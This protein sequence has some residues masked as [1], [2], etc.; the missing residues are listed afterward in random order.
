MLIGVT[1]SIRN[2]CYLLGFGTW[3][4]T[5]LPLARPGA[6]LRDQPYN[7]V[8]SVITLSAYIG[9]TGGLRCADTGRGGADVGGGIL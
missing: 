8:H 6:L 3:H 1:E 9:Y 2:S 7:K 5:T 4:T